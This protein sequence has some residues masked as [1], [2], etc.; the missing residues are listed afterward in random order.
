MST[1]PVSK[2]QLD[3]VGT[4]RKRFH[5]LAT[6]KELVDISN[7]EHFWLF[8]V[9]W[10]RVCQNNEFNSVKQLLEQYNTDINIYSDYMRKVRSILVDQ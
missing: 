2:I 8:W 1:L 10:T 6:T 4:V 3:S 9:K 7:N 5:E